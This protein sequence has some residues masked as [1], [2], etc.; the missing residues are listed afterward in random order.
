M[1]PWLMESNVGI[2]T[3][4]PYV[5]KVAALFVR[6]VLGQNAID[7][8][9]YFM[10]FKKWLGAND[11][12]TKLKER[13]ITDG[14]PVR[15]GTRPLWAGKVYRT[16]VGD[17]GRGIYYSSN[18]FVAKQYGAIEKTSIK[19]TNPLVLTSDEAYALANEY[20]TVVLSDEKTKELF[21]V[22]GREKLKDAASAQKL[23]NS[24]RLTDDMIK[25]GHDGLI[26]INKG[27]LEIV[28][29]RPYR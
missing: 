10:E 22:V 8:H 14:I 16:D 26:V 3:A 19:F 7:F 9:K 28:D 12:K 24:Q 17:F 23:Q 18:Y 27:R 4:L 21:K 11:T 1:E 2:A 29:Y 13:A 25:K 20:Q 5:E 15:R 6:I